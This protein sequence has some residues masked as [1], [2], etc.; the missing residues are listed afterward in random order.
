MVQVNKHT[1]KRHESRQHGNGVSSAQVLWGA[2]CP[3]ECAPKIA[4]TMKNV[5]LDAMD[6]CVQDGQHR[7]VGNGWCRGVR[8]W[9]CPADA[10]N[11]RPEA[12]AMTAHFARVLVAQVVATVTQYVLTGPLSRP[13]LGQERTIGFMTPQHTAD[14]H[15]GMHMSSKIAKMH[16]LEHTRQWH[17]AARIL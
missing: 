16:V 8:L 9:R 2:A 11:M 17:I 4:P 15:V 14:V 6:K 13:W 12:L 3:T 1:H 5:R 10:V 7:R